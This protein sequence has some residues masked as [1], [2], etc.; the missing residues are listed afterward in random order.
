MAQLDITHLSYTYP[1]ASSPALQ[2]VS[3][4]IAPGEFVAIV[5][6]N[7]SGKSTLCY[8]L[9]GFIPHFFHGTLTGQIALAGQPTT[10]VTLAEL[11][12]RIGLVFQNPANQMSRARLSVFEEIAFGLENI[13]L[14]TVAMPERVNW[15]MDQVGVSRLAQRSPLMLSGGEQQR[16]A[17]A[18]I[19][20]MQPQVLVL[21]EP[22][23]QLDPLGAQQ[24]FEVLHR[25]SQQGTT[26]VVAEHHLEAIAQYTTR[27]IALHGGKVIL[28]GSPSQVLAQPQLVA[29]GVGQTRYTQIAQLAQAQGLW[30]PLQPLPTTL[31]QAVEGFQRDHPWPQVSPPPPVDS[32]AELTGR[33]V[34][35]QPSP[36]DLRIQNLSFS[37]PGGN[38]ILQ[39]L[40]LSI[41]A[42]E[43]VALLGQ[44]GAGK[45]TLVRHFNGLLHPTQG[46]VWLG[47]QLTTQQSTAQLSRRVG[48]VFQNPDDQLFC[49]TVYAELEFGLKP[50][51]GS[52]HDITAR[53]RQALDWVGLP[54]ADPAS[55][56]AL[57]DCNPYDFTLPWRKQ[58]TLAAVLVMD[59]DIFILDEPTIGLDA[60]Q[61]QRLVQLLQHLR[62]RRKTVVVISHNLDFVADTCDRLIVLHQ[63]QA[64][65]DGTP[66]EV[67]SHQDLLASSGLLP[68]QTTRLGAA[69]NLPAP[70]CTPETFLAL[71]RKLWS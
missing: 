54:E 7:G 31:Q 51:K 65:L 47:Q 45:T 11:A 66:T 22:T 52:R 36:Y 61:I 30:P 2:D 46:S 18:T 62:S 71:Y 10:Q 59:P 33:T 38:P 68:P 40:T 43:Q 34:A 70:V 57:E 55:A 32:T 60:N 27:A 58:I 5:G 9:T 16:V 42:G 41:A 56:V 39:H 35:T 19:L 3:F 8:A 67:L 6:S 53:I 20:A 24:I 48:Y 44:N 1:H 37:Y 21:D 29:Y 17:I 28:D 13:G 49:S 15:A 14:P 26:I 12:P 4:Q 23:A 50:L 69:L 25:L 63:G 64:V